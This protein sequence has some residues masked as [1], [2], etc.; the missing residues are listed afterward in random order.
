MRR[1]GILRNPNPQVGP[2]FHVISRADN[3]WQ[4]RGTCWQASWLVGWLAGRPGTGDWGRGCRRRRPRP[5]PRP[6]IKCGL[7]IYSLMRKKGKKE[8]RSRDL[9]LILSY[10]HLGKVNTPKPLS[11]LHTS[12]LP[13]Y[14]GTPRQLLLPPLQVAISRDIPKTFFSLPNTSLQHISSVQ[15]IA[16]A[17]PLA[18]WPPTSPQN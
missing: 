12:Y 9:G 14:V 13:R 15:P 4:T 18:S 8:M 10:F 1:D 17:Y 16:L 3:P 5:N 6:C 2:S 7:S 11:K